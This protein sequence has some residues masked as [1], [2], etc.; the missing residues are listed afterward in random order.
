[1]ATGPVSVIADKSYNYQDI[2]EHKYFSIRDILQ[3]TAGVMILGD[4][5]IL[6]TRTTIGISSG[7]ST[8]LSNG[9]AAGD[10]SNP[11]P[12]PVYLSMAFI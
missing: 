3:R 11:N 12:E 4:Q 1:M 7:S 6:R 10:Y 5:I 8:E 2:E 9:E